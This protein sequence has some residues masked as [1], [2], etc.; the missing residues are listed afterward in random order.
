MTLNPDDDDVVLLL[1]R[2][3]NYCDGKELLTSLAYF[4]ST[5]LEER[6]GDSQNKGVKLGIGAKVRSTIRRLSTEK[7]GKMGAREKGRNRSGTDGGR[8]NSFLKRLSS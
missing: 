8:R 4:C 1:N 3:R 6:I 2:F 5:I 7:G